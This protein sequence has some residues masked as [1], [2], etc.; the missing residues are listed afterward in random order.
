MKLNKIF[1]SS[2]DTNRRIAEIKVEDRILSESRTLAGILNINPE[3]KKQEVYGFGGALTESSAYVLSTLSKEN[4]DKILEL[5]Y[6]DNGYIFGRTHLNSCDFSLENWAIEEKKGCIDFNRSDKYLLPLL[7]KV[8]ELTCG[9][10]KLM[11]SPWSPAAWMKDNKEMNHG[12]HLL[13][14]AAASWAADYT[15]YI[16]HLQKE[17]IKTWAVSIQNE[18]EATQTWDSCLYTAEEEALFAEKHLGPELERKGLEDIKIFVWDHNRDGLYRRLKASLDTAPK[19]IS[20][21]AYHWYS[22][23][24]FENVE[25]C[26]KEFPNMDLIFTEGCIEGGPRPGKW[27]TGERYAHNII[28]DLR[29]GCNAWIDWNIVLD[30]QGG[31]NH[32]GNFCDAPV[33]ADK[34]K[35]EYYLNSSFYY[36]GHFSRFIKPGARI[37]SSSISSWMTPAT[38]SGR[39][40]DYMECLAAINTDGS[41][42]LIVMNRT[43]ADMHFTLNIDSKAENTSGY[44]SHTDKNEIFVCP[45]RSIQTYIFK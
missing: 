3:E 14:D 33:L 21:A 25:R 45:E 26:R 37:I 4:A 30:M 35:N 28:N 29:S 38:P 39:M 6:K 22:G 13:P 34:N 8:N 17:G 19:Y 7:K 15:A 1:E 2:K 31:P 12:G 16:E 23:D 24:Q 20:G 11:I 42:V 32:V 43:E 5:Y 10:L 36:I 9:N 27:F 44:F 41:L 40:G 18:T